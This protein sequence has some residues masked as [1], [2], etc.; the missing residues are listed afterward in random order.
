M[1]PVVPAVVTCVLCAD[2]SVVGNVSGTNSSKFTW[3][4]HVSTQMLV[5][6][7]V[8]H[9][10]HDRHTNGSACQSLLGVV[11]VKQRVCVCVV[12]VVDKHGVPLMLL[13]AMLGV[14][15]SQP[16]SCVPPTDSSAA[17]ASIA[18]CSWQLPLWHPAA[19][20]LGGVLERAGSGTPGGLVSH[21][22]TCFNGRAPPTSPCPLGEHAVPLPA[23]QW[24]VHQPV[25]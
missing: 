6:Q 1:L 23:V 9:V 15:M 17:C 13:A 18:Y 11:L 22:F 16:Q 4:A 25:M 8:C 2:P 12:P 5:W 7:L 14:C 3:L 21:C 19:V 10:Q 20:C 24:W